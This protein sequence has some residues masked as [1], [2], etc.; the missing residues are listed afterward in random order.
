MFGCKSSL[1]KHLRMHKGEELEAVDELEVQQVEIQQEI[2]IMEEDDV[3]V[4]ENLG[5]LGSE[6]I[7]FINEPVEE[8]VIRITLLG[9]DGNESHMEVISS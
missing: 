6:V 8:N 7:E 3:I 9:L 4:E 1:N 2:Q 5:E